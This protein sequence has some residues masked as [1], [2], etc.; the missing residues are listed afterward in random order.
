MIRV[1]RLARSD[2][3][4]PLPLERDAARA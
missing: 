4:W 2:C 1:N 3:F